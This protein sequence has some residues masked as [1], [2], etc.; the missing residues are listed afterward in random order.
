MGRLAT[1]TGLE[2]ATVVLVANQFNPSI[3]SEHWLAKHGIVPDDETER[4]TLMVPGLSQLVTARFAIEGRPNR[5]QVTLASPLDE[6]APTVVLDTIGRIA[7][8]LPETPYSALGLNFHWQAASTDRDRVASGQREMFAAAGSPV[9]GF[10]AA[11]DARFGAYLS[12]DVLGFRLKLIVL[13][14]TP[15]TDDGPAEGMNCQFNFHKALD[16]DAGPSAVAQAIGLWPDAL[17]ISRDM[18]AATTEW[19]HG[20]DAD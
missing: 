15:E 14:V 18:F 12:K 1:V 6:T 3:L 5:V 8:L 11:S 20:S 19:I 9:Y 2:K 10:F 4:K 17:A 7:Q 16:H 13:P